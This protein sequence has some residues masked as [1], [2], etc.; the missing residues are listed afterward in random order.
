MADEST[1]R[2]EYLATFVLVCV[3]AIIVAGAHRSCE[4]QRG[5]ERWCLEHGG[6]YMHESCVR[7]VLE[8]K[9]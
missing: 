4:Y 5:L 6:V 1:K 3:L 9:P 2:Q 7:P 8:T